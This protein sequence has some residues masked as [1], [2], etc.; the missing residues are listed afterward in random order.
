VLCKTLATHAA[1][2]LLGQLLLR[3]RGHGDAAVLVQEVHLQQ[4]RLTVVINSTFNE[5]FLANVLRCTSTEAGHRWHIHTLVAS[6]SSASSMVVSIESSLFSISIRSLSA[7]YGSCLM[8]VYV[9]CVSVWPCG[10]IA[11]ALWC[12]V[13]L[14]LNVLDECCDGVLPPPAIGPDTCDVGDR[15][16]LGIVTVTDCGDGRRK[17]TC[18]N[19]ILYIWNRTNM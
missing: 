17:V 4:C 9:A 6:S 1:R 5:Y 16:L 11:C 8:V 13:D 19:I 12:D 18:I 7:S 14:S 2:N 10:V 3:R 15:R